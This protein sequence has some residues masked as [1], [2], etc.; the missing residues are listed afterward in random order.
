MMKTVVVVVVVCLAAVGVASS[1]AATSDTTPQQLHIALRGLGYDM[2]VSW[3]TEDNTATSTV[4]Y[5]T[6]SGSYTNKATG[7]SDTYYKGYNHD[8]V[9][10]GLEA[11]TTYYY[12]VGDATGGWSS[13]AS[14]T[15]PPAPNRDQSYTAA[16]Y[17]DMGVDN[18]DA[19]SNR[20]IAEK[21]GVG[22]GGGCGGCALT[23]VRCPP[24]GRL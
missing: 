21:V 10:E 7:S 23:L 6:K 14:F 15:S 5:G 19:T 17:G 3:Y 8:A 2:A 4:Q 13:E 18:S 9:L 24:P 1:S 20:L 22:G 12:I 16:V 11:A